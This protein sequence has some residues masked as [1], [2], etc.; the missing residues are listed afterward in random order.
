MSRLVGDE[1]VLLDMASGFYFGLDG[2]GKRI[3][4]SVA[5]GQTIAQTAATIANEYDVEQERA[6][7]DVVDF[8][9]DLLER[10]LLQRS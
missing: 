10:G 8:V 1:T 3:W 5:D 9:S 6:Q 7:S 4:E 2:V